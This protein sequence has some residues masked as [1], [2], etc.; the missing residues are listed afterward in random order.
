MKNKRLNFYLLLTGLGFVI[1]ITAGFII[2]NS[3]RSMTINQNE[4]SRNLYREHIEN[5]SMNTLE[6]MAHYIEKRY[7][8]LQDTQRIK[9]EMGTDWFWELTDEWSDIANTFNF[10]FVYY[11]EKKGDNYYFLISTFISRDENSE[12]LGESVWQEQPP[13]F[14]D[15]AWE[16]KQ[17]TGSPEPFTDEWGTAITA[18]RPIISYGEVVG[19]LGVDYDI[20]FIDN[21][22][23]EQDLLLKEQEDIMMRWISIVLIGSFFVILA[24]TGCMIWLGST[25]VMISSNQKEADERTRI[26][27]DTTPLCCNLFDKDFN[28]LDCNKEAEK[29]FGITDKRDF[30][31]RFFDFSPVCQPDGQNSKEK[32]FGFFKK[33]FEEGSAS[34]EWIHLI[35]GELVPC[36][37]NLV[38]VKYKDSFIIAA[39]TRDLRELKA[40]AEKIR[41]AE[42]SKEQSEEA[43][44]A[45]SFFLARMSH[46]I[47]TPMNAI[48][49]ITEIQLQNEALPL[50]TQE[51]LVKINNSGY[52]L[53]GIIN[54]IL[55]LSKIEAG[56]MELFPV[57][58]DVASLLHDTAQLNKVRYDNKPI[59]FKINVNENIPS[60]LF[61]DELRIKQILNNIL[62]NAFKYTEK[63]VVMLLADI[64]EGNKK[65]SRNI[66]LVFRIS[67]TGQGM[68]DNE[69]KKLFD[70]YSRFNIDR[71]KEG[72][73]LGM[74]ITRL[75]VQMMGGEI[76]VE[77]E[78][79][80]GSIFTVRL[81]QRKVDDGIL[82]KELTKDMEEFNFDILSKMKKSSQIVR[83]YMPY[84]N[85]LVVDDVETNLYV[86]KGLLSPYGLSIETTLNGFDAIEKIKSGSSYDIIFMDHFMPKMDGIEATKIIR[87]LGYTKPVIAL[88]ANALTGQAENFL[89]NGF[90]DFI[91]K[92]IDIRQLNA[93]L[94]KF[95]RDIHPNDVVDA[96][97]QQQE[98][99]GVNVLKSSSHPELAGA[100]I[101]DA[102]KSIE[103][104]KMLHATNYRRN[105]DIQS[106]I[107]NVHAMKSALAN[108]NE[109]EMSNFAGRLENAGRNKDIELMK[110]E[111][112]A[113]MDSLSALIEKLKPKAEPAK[114]ELT[115]DDKIFLHERLLVL[116]KACADL[117]KRTAKNILS[118]LKQIAL[119]YSI[120]EFLDTISKHLLHSDFREA[121]ET[122]NKLEKS[123]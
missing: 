75:L 7:P 10:V 112:H 73:G 64:E 8:V 46:E 89:S 48:L 5:I 50:E 88:T 42:A 52:L 44:K 26:M 120:H 53:L 30:L 49:G 62:S 55:D 38:R 122:A 70:K 4:F 40:A 45:K 9:Q 108:I 106:Y 111:T 34:V 110:N 101:R 57:N 67:D 118:E 115:E 114:G 91:S 58:Y 121:I 93:T 59:D 18:V 66:T 22:V 102:K 107:I 71:T 69:L 47:R 11:I 84:G 116:K 63:G 33:T 87:E 13:A 78:H 94:N 82:G 60:T 97:R 92:P 28:F 21:L 25:S 81:P 36:D 100:F 39:Y 123:F 20:S 104:L 23:E 80:K 74:N 119:P 17:P 3:F 16:T 56:K 51:A 61:G 65:N 103:T 109:D 35:N 76:S 90:D 2:F 86:A 96:A 105:D 95:I 19:L 6:N 31:D 29:L 43:N 14:Y 77:S 54:D 98:K 15:Q 1:V 24:I 83:E 68:T 85:V 12:L 41:K 27:L 99:S 79:G 117:D 113:F 32:A 37:V 72:T